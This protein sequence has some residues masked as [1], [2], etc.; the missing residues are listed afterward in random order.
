[1]GWGWFAPFGAQAF[2]GE[3]CILPRNPAPADSEIA[4][5]TLINAL[6]RQNLDKHLWIAEIGRIREYSSNR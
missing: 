4:L 6:A 1:M 5:T 2:L 3:R